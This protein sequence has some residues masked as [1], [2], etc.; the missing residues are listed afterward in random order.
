LRHR[1]GR[2]AIE[3]LE[4]EVDAHHDCEYKES[5][6]R[7]KG[8]IHIPTEACEEGC[9]DDEVALRVEVAAEKRHTAGEPRELAVCIVEHGLQLDEHRSG[10]ELPSGER[11]RARDACCAGG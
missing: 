11:N 9:V 2:P 1:A 7:C 5:E 3:P 6:K 8:R 10:D 4:V